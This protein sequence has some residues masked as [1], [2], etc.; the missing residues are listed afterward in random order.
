MVIFILNACNTIKTKE[1][2]MKNRTNISNEF[3]TQLQKTTAS[4][5]CN[6]DFNYTMPAVGVN[7]SMRTRM[8]EKNCHT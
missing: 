3:M 6:R 2:L 1:I 7:Y 4:T 8:K 5:V